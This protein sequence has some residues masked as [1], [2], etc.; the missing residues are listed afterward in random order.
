VRNKATATA[1][2][3]N[4]WGLHMRTAAMVVSEATQHKAKITLEANKKTAIAKSITSLLMLEAVQGTQITVRAMGQNAD[5]AARAIAELINSGFV[6]H[7]ESIANEPQAFAGIGL[8]YGI[9]SGRAHILPSDSTDTP[10]YSI[11]AN[12]LAAEKKRLKTAITRARS[13]FRK[14]SKD[15]KSRIGS[16]ELRSFVDLNIGL[17]K[18]DFISKK[19]LKIID[20]D[21]VNA[22]WALKVCV[23]QMLKEF[24]SIE[25]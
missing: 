24:A 8:Q 22:E 16:E 2:V 20:Q 21:L 10:Y 11:T 7:P 17:L 3:V 14:L 18:E 19:P 25:D 6:G 15:L 23:D 5:I 13:D 9:A 12:A 1:S 4:E